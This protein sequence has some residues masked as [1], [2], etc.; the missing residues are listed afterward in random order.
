[1]GKHFAVVLALLVLCS[2]SSAPK[3]S[4]QEYSAPS[5]APVRE[6][7]NSAK[8]AVDRASTHA[9]KAKAAIGQAEKVAPEIPDLRAAL[10]AANSE[11]DELTK[12]L[13]NAAN[14]LVVADGRIDGLQ[15]ANAVLA[16]VAN[17]SVKEKNLAL[18]QKKAAETQAA[19]DRRHVHR[20]KRYICG[21]GAAIAFLFAFQFRGLLMLAGPWV[22]GIVLLGAPA[23]VFA[24]LWKIL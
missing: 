9:A 12:E 21:A 7:V 1:V 23:A 20:L 19:E 18:A 17:D 3:H 13:L 16:K 24:F 2:C 4:H 8:A 11:T 5:T 15:K 22:L 6:K 10:G 14:D